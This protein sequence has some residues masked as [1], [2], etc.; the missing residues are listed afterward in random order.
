[1]SD[2]ERNLK[3]VRYLEY[4]Q[5]ICMLLTLLAF[6]DI[7]SRIDDAE[8][9]CRLMKDQINLKRIR[10][11]KVPSPSIQIL[12]NALKYDILIY[13]LSIIKSNELLEKCLE[14]H[15][16]CTAETG[17]DRGPPGPIGPPG[18]PGNPG[19]PGPPG[20]D[21]LMGM[22]GP[23]GPQGPPGMPGKHGICPKCSLA[24]NFEMLRKMECPKIEQM[25]CPTQI[26]SD[27]EGGPRY[28]ERQLPYFVRLMLLNDT[29]LMP[30]ID[31]CVRICLLNITIPSEADIPP[32]S[33][34]IA[35]IEGAT[36]HCY[37]NDVGKPIFHAHSNTY[38]GSWMRDAYP[39]NGQDMMKRWMTKHFQGDTVEEYLD[40]GDM[41]RQRIFVTHQ[42]PY[43]Y[44]GTNLIFFNGSIYFHRAGTPKIGKYELNSKVYDEVLIDKHAAHGGNNYLFNLSMNYFDLAVDENALWVLFHY[45]DEEFLSVSKL[46]IGNLTIYETWNLT[47]I[48][49]TEVANGFVV[50]G[51]LY[52]VRS[53]YELKSEIAIAYDLYR[54]KY[55]K[56][57]IHWINPY[58]N[59]NM[60]AYNPYDK[61]IYIY[62]HGYLLTV[63]ARITWTAK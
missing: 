62:D 21:G 3:K 50:C 60:I 55:R 4:C 36:A 10:R 25:R 32:I 26:I 49:H 7:Y 9:K 13:S 41:R 20:R 63:P 56:P 44:D 1:M 38:F 59:A 28:I 31:K 46:D 42:M 47:L 22:P 48:N 35:Y 57:N 23:P 52:L 61:R 43:L 29:D 2:E 19:K 12:L 40:E 16:Y 34:E 24:E 45:E 18:L 17:T 30:E 14:I 58:R 54:N 51:V 33:T 8:K 27:S 6:A 5:T 37:L 39:Q 11:D 53:S 15:Q